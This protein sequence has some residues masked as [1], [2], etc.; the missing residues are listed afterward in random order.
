[1]MAPTAPVHRRCLLA[2][3]HRQQLEGPFVGTHRGLSR[4]PTV[5]TL[6]GLAAQDVGGKG[7]QH[8]PWRALDCLLDRQPKRWGQ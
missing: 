7:S 5:C 2:L 8:S 1:M 4:D 3:W 6:E